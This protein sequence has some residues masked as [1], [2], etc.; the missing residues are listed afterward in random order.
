M[1]LVHFTIVDRRNNILHHNDST[2]DITFA[3]VKDN[4]DFVKAYI[5]VIDESIMDFLKA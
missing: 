5:K 4:I 2:S 3:D 1:N